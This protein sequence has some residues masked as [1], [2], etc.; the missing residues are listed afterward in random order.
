[1]TFQSLQVYYI[2]I[3]ESWL[4]E[5][6]GKYMYSLGI[7][8]SVDYYSV[9]IVDDCYTNHSGFKI[10]HHLPIEKVFFLQKVRSSPTLR[11]RPLPPSLNVILTA[12]STDKTTCLLSGAPAVDNQNHITFH[13]T[14][15]SHPRVSTQYHLT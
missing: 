13:R 9:Q 14:P 6:K 12:H 2:D 15:L 11:I 1:M 7:V 8:E 3:K 4:C 10:A 5:K